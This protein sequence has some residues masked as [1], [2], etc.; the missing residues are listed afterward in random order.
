M[1]LSR[2]FVSDY[3]DLD[4]NLSIKQIAEDMT[5][6]GNE[7]DEASKLIN[8]TNL[9][10][11]EVLECID[12]PDSDH[13]HVCKV[14]VGSEVLDIVCGAP[15]VRKGLKVIVALP[16]AKLPGGEIKKGIIRG[17]VSNGMLCSIAELGL[18]N[19]F[20]TDKDKN[21]IHE[22]P[23][24]TAVGTDPIKALGL[25][26]EVIDFELT[27]NRGDLL[28]ILGM[29]YELGAIYKKPV[30]DI[31]LSYSEVDEDINDS[32]K[33]EVKTDDCSMFLA[34]KVKNVTIK[35][36]PDFI[37]NRLI[38]S[39]IRPINNVVDISNYVMLETGQP[40][41]YY[42]ADSLGDTLIVRNAKESEQLV[43]LDSQ[44][45]TL[46]Q[47]DIVIANKDEAIGLA[48]VMGG[49][50]T[51]VENETKNIIIESAIF[52]SVKIRRTSKRILRS[53]A[54]NRF[55]KGL[56]PKRTYMALQRSCNLLEKYADATVVGG[57]ISYD[58]TN[59]EDKT[60]FLEISKIEKVLGIK[61]EDEVIIDILKSLGFIVE[62]Q[63]NV[64]K[65][66]VPSRRLDI[67]IK[68]DLIEEIGRIYGMD[69][70]K[71]K[72]PTFSSKLGTFDRTKRDI[73][74]KMIS[75][76]LNETLSYTL[77]PES[78]VYKYT[79]DTFERIKVADPMSEDRSTLRYSLLYSLKE[80]YEYNK[81]RNYKD[82]SIFEI[83]KSFYKENDTYKEDLK[84]ATLM[85]GT[86]SLGLKKTKVD[87]YILKGIIEELLDYL[88]YERRYSFVIDD[89][90]PCELHPGMSASIIMQGNPIGVI[91]KLHP[92]VSKDDI[93]VAEINLTKLLKNKASRMNFK[94]LSKF[95]SIQK[96]LAFIVKKDVTSS[97]LEAVIKK[98][99]GRLLTNIEV[100]D[101][102]TGENV[103]NDE[104]SIA[105]SLTFTDPNK[106]LTDEEVT[107]VFKNIIKD[108]ENKC[109]ATLRDK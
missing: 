43:T 75:L 20:L 23:Y 27:S 56:D 49:L 15:N 87:F 2:K 85:T 8:C 47:D 21:G 16:G 82:I 73:R 11:G 74:N 7:Y 97:A 77:I 68:E 4:E 50:S 72:L 41:H 19:K 9:T 37:K 22:L 18:D 42:D 54:S 51:E 94:E 1:K 84:L 26:D 106:T 53:E 13:L 105:Y 40:L 99:G 6:V 102:Y 81:A 33:V 101:V 55:E 3:V 46:T 70:I 83:G 86:Y 17:Q 5:S 66:T 35:E 62:K 63:D 44:T 57:M 59:K 14:D 78:E 71:G 38:A 32:F 29:A 65:V 34:K 88:G 30:K 109:N 31:D 76:G 79:K 12:H 104:K 89:T 39:G 92:N 80:V 28:S 69:N 93:Y 52:D 95:P 25:D 100:F 10:V 45:R 96:D 67:N 60:I 58:K 48:G 98:S 103:G 61:I 24:E 108:V 91:G 107:E 36:S 64:L 90:I